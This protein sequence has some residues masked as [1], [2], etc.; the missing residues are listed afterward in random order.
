[1]VIFLKSSNFNRYTFA[2]HESAFI[3]VCDLFTCV[4]YYLLLA[5]TYPPLRLSCVEGNLE[6]VEATP[7]TPLLV[8]L[9][10]LATRERVDT[11]G[12]MLTTCVSV[13][14]MSKTG[15]INL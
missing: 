5:Y 11:L 14:H 15:N 2:S 12:G 9:T 6:G 4:V 7:T 10:S 1:M 8:P 3:P 13:A